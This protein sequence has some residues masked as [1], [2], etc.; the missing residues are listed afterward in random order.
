MKLPQLPV[1]S[2]PFPQPLILKFL[3]KP[4]L[5][6]L[7]TIKTPPFNLGAKCSWNDPMNLSSRNIL[8]DK[9]E[10]LSMKENNLFCDNCLRISS[11]SYVL[12]STTGRF[13]TRYS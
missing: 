10:S 4:T 2:N 12:I 8:V 9:L 13:N 1:A 7:L 6:N 5:P 3:N 11:F